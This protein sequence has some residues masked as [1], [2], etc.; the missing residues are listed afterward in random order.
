VPVSAAPAAVQE[1]FAEL[2]GALEALIDQ[3]LRP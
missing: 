2:N 3:A 1:W